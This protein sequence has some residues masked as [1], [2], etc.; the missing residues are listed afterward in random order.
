MEIYD[1]YL[2]MGNKPNKEYILNIR[3]QAAM[4]FEG[5]SY[6]LIAEDESRGI[7]GFAIIFH[8]E[9]EAPVP[10][11][12]AFINLIEIHD[13]SNHKKGIASC[14]VQKIIQLEEEKNT[15][16]VRAYCEINKLKQLANINCCMVKH[17]QL[18]WLQK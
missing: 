6:F 16:Q 13:E 12:E 1:M 3:P 5:R 10:A 14:L 11:N 9:I 17:C 7:L 4:L 2:R 18:D 15:Y 8:R